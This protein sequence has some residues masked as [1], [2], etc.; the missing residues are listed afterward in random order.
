MSQISR[1]QAIDAT[2][3]HLADGIQD[4]SQQQTLLIRLIRVLDQSLTTLLANAIVPHGFTEPTLHTLMLISSLEPHDVSPSLLC[5]MVAQPPQNMTR[6]LRTL[7]DQGYLE[8]ETDEK[9]GR[10]SRLAITPKGRKRLNEVLPTTIP[11]VASGFS[12]L[13]LRE[14]QTLE[15]LLRKAIVSLDQAAVTQSLPPVR[16]KRSS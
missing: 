1:L 16:S 2:M 3:P 14:Q 11:A 9:D 12:G 8:R 4:L 6:I 13:T 5:Q 10:R 15:S 7:G